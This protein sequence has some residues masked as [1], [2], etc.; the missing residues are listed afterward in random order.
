MASGV[1][2]SEMPPIAPRVAQP[3]ETEMVDC[4]CTLLPRQGRVAAGMVRSVRV[5]G[6][7]LGRNLRP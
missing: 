6:L 7:V 1:T 4:F 2:I 3:E 5:A